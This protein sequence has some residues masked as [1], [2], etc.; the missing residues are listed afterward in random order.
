MRI[1]DFEGRPDWGAIVQLAECPTCG[2]PAG[3]PC[4]NVGAAPGTLLARQRRNDWHQIRK[5]LGLLIHLERR[6][7]AVLE[8]IERNLPCTP[9]SITFQ[10]ILMNPTAAG[11][12]QVFTGT[13]SPNGSVF[14]AGTTFTITSNDPAVSPTVDSTG[15]IVSVTYP[16]GWVEST[17]TPLAFTW[18]TSTF[19]PVPSSSPSQITETITPSAAPSPTVT[20]T[21]VNFAQTQ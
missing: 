8:E 14:P 12:T 17:E 19:V 4:R 5:E 15:L 9:T 11:Q 21:S 20:P 2:A 3:L 18:Q 7:L 1:C 6:E 10:E 16:E 13:L